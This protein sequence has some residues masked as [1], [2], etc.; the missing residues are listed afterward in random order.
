[1]AKNYSQQDFTSTFE[2]LLSIVEASTTKWSPRNST[3][4]DPGVVLLKLM[5]LLEDK[6]NY[7]FDMSM[8]QAY[9]D[10]VTDRQS[11]YDLLKM[12]GY[13]MKNARGATGAVY[14]T[15]IPSAW[16]SQDS[17]IIIPK[18]STVLTDATGTLKFF[19]TRDVTVNGGASTEQISLPVQAG[20]PFQVT[21]DGNETFSVKDID[22]DGKL[23]LGR[24]DLAQNGIFVRTAVPSTTFGRDYD[25]VD[26]WAYLDFAILKPTGNWYMVETAESGEMYIQ[27]PADFA[28]RIANKQFIV[29]GVCEAGSSTNVA[30]NLLSTF[31]NGDELGDYFSVSQPEA[32]YTGQDAESISQATANYYATK[33]VCDAIVT[34][35]DFT[36]AIRY[37]LRG[38]SE[39]SLKGTRYFSNVLVETAQDRAIPVRTICNGQEYT[40]YVPD[41][42]PTNEIDVVGLNY[43]NNYSASFSRFGEGTKGKTDRE[44]FSSDIAEQLRNQRAA[45][46]RIKINEEGKRLLAVTTPEMTIRMANYTVDKATALKTKIQEYFYSNY[47]ADKLTP[48]K[49]LD[50]QTIVDDITA[51][52]PDILSVAMSELQYKIYEKFRPVDGESVELSDSKKVEAVARSVLAGQVPLFRYANRQNTVSKSTTTYDMLVSDD[53]Y[54]ETIVRPFG[55]TSFNQLGTGRVAPKIS[56]DLANIG[57]LKSKADWAA[58]GKQVILQGNAMIQFR[59]K[60]LRS[61][62]DY[63]Y[64]VQ[65]VCNID[66]S[67]ELASSVNIIYTSTLKPRSILAEGSVLVP[68]ENLEN[69]KGILDKYFDGLEVEKDDDGEPTGRTYLA[70]GKPYTV[71]AALELND[72]TSLRLAADSVLAAGSVIIPGSK[73]NKEEYA[74]SAIEDGTS[75]QVKETDEIKLFDSSGNLLKE[76]KKGEWVSP[77][78]FTMKNTKSKTLLSSMATVSVMEDDCSVIS[79]DYKYFLTLQRSG[80]LELKANQEY[81]LEENEVLLY[82]DQGV[83]E[84]VSLGP[85]TI[86]RADKEIT[87][88]NHAFTD[89]EDVITSYFEQ[90]PEMIYA[91]ATEVST[92]AAGRFV[93]FKGYNSDTKILELDGAWRELLPDAEAI[94]YSTHKDNSQAGEVLA[95]FVGN[96]YSFRLV[97]KIQTDE[98]GIAVISSPFAGSLMVEDEDDDGNKVKEELSIASAEEK[99]EQA[100]IS[101]TVPFTAIIPAIQGEYYPLLPAGSLALVSYAVKSVSSAPGSGTTVTASADTLLLEKDINSTNTAG[102]SS[103]S[104]DISDASYNK[105]IKLVLFSVRVEKGEAK[106][107]LQKNAETS[108]EVI[109][110]QDGL[111]DFVSKVVSSDGIITISENTD[112]A[113]GSIIAF[114]PSVKKPY[115]GIDLIPGSKV[116]IDNLS[117][118]TD[119]AAETGVVN[120]KD[121]EKDLLTAIRKLDTEKRFNYL[122]KPLEEFTEPATSQAFLVA[123]HPFNSKVLPYVYLDLLKIK[124][125]AQ[126]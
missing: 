115:L 102:V 75:Y 82:A 12:L 70:E 53:S 92:Y 73:I 93:G 72:K 19:V 64:G 113:R 122:C 68:T 74:L 31:A 95:N 61:T 18:F 69:K 16:K 51:L 106:F 60:L 79:E 81:M 99:S 89:V 120:I 47:S 32:F 88:T 125:I 33:D 56:V 116:F 110:G 6:A 22:E 87:L 5:A 37:V 41:E 49:P 108:S 59:K 126:R 101:S 29:L 4:A 66:V 58:G 117:Y 63:G 80:D 14:L 84:Y 103:I 76:F 48:G 26:D 119:Y 7:R 9:L 85:G 78:G 3:E 107:S 121:A 24:T 15:K 35:S 105:P 2:E 40:L 43:S 30:A 39:D 118:V 8:A 20:A 83:T 17:A 77:T 96:T 42:K 38:M 65:Y 86:I 52:S 57:F 45:D 10:T 90:V 112:A 25:Y 36:S 100:Y 109:T 123:A 46:V 91:Q 98:E 97:W 11:A 54:E 13:I 111:Y 124:V 55:V 27:F 50:Y 114:V 1:M 71:K 67:P 34:A 94:V 21:K 44:L 62:Q 28:T 104:I 23:Y